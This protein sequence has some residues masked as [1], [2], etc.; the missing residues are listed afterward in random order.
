MIRTGGAWQMMTNDLPHRNTCYHYYRLW[1]KLGY[2]EQIHKALRDITLLSAR[3]KPRQLRFSIFKAL[4][5]LANPEFVVMMRL[6]SYRKKRHILVDT[7]GNILSLKVTTADKQDREGAQTLL[8]VPAVAF[9]WLK[10]IWAD[11]SYSGKLDSHMS[12]IIRHRR[13]KLEIVIRSD[14]IKESSPA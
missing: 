11:G 6:R 1:A 13:V 2:W 4:G 12:G 7:Q 5:Q 10:L 14:D 3:K 8:N 9:V